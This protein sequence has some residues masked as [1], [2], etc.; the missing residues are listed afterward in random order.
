[1]YLIWYYSSVRR[2][3]ID[4]LLNIFKIKERKK[5][6]EKY[7]GD[8]KSRRYHPEHDVLAAFCASKERLLQ[9]HYE[10][11][12]H[13]DRGGFWDACCSHGCCQDFFAR[14]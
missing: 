8:R 13:P 7:T 5:K 4:F 14:T 12:L 1:M 9:T 2:D 3:T 10:F 11:I 6:K